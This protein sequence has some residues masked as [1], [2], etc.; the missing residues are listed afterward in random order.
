ML[1]YGILAAIVAAAGCRNAPSP[2]VRC[3]VGETRCDGEL[4]Q[5]CDPA[6]RWQ[7]MLDCRRVAELNQAA[8]TCGPVLINDGEVGRLE[9]HSCVLAD[10]MVATTLDGG[11]Q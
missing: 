9:G 5:I 7:T 8:F 1:K 6:G 3:P 11:A 2:S 10:P 4:A